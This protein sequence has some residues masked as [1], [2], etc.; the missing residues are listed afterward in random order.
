MARVSD[1]I[2]IINNKTMEKILLLMFL[3]PIMAQAQTIKLYPKVAMSYGHEKVTDIKYIGM[4]LSQ[5]TR[6]IANSDS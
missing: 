4:F 6:L 1:N 2:N 5:K 3:L